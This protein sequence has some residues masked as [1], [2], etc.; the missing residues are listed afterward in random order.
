MTNKKIPSKTKVK[1]KAK[2]AAKKK[3]VPKKP[4]R[5][6]GYLEGFKTIRRKPRD[7]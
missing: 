7:A 4:F 2:P 6:G 5:T 1:P 3:T